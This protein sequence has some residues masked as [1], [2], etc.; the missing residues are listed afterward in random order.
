A[1][2]RTTSAASNATSEEHLLRTTSV[3]STAASA[4]TPQGLKSRSI[5]FSS[6][7]TSQK[8]MSL[9]L[10]S[11]PSALFGSVVPGANMF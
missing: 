11:T 3:A 10:P 7:P 6:F 5:L 4:S 1:L 8:L 9:M 2:A